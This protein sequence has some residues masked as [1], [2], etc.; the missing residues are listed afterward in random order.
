M[1]QIK[2]LF[3]VLSS[4]FGIEDGRIA[5][6]KTTVTVYPKSQEIEIIQENLFTI[7]QSENDST[8]LAEQ[9][10][11]I[12]NSKESTIS[13]VKDLDNFTVKKLI[14][15]TSKNTIQPHVMLRF[16]TE[17]DL[18]AMGIWYDAA[19]NKFSI[20]HIPK[21]NIKT[22]DG[23]LEGNYWVFNGGATFSFTIEPFLEMP[24]NFQ[25]IKKPLEEII[26]K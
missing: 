24:E 11:T 19:N 23:K 7:I 5:A 25:K 26:Y 15:S 22:K 17:K 3:Y 10:K 13:W 21:D 1:E 12:I 4:F 6:E 20:N 14:F 8:I 9:W 18:R 2:I 16:T